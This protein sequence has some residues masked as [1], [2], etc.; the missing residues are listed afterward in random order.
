M[1]ILQGKQPRWDEGSGCVSRVW[2]CTATV[3][4]TQHKAVTTQDRD[5]E[6]PQ[7]R[8]YEI[9]PKGAKAALM[10]SVVISGLRSPTKTWK[11]S[12][13]EKRKEHSVVED[14]L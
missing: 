13:G 1:E 4:L 10:S 12:L 14:A 5:P 2:P 7:K 3:S 9:L 11:W 8:T 6:L